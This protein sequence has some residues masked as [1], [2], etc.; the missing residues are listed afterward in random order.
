MA[1][2]R[3]QREGGRT[4]DEI[5]WA[6]EQLEIVERP[7]GPAA[8]ALIAAGIGVFFLG[9]FTVLSEQ[10]TGMHDWLQFKDRVGPLSGK[11]VMAVVA[12]VVSWAFL[13][14]VLWKRNVNLN[15]ALIITGVLIAGGFIGTFPKFFQLFP[16]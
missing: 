7:N 8:A 9:L 12:Y 6:A 3:V 15:N 2:I 4:V 11:T 10:S 1:N 16:L 14:P 5:Q 13:A